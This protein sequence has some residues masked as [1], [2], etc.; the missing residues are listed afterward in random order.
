METNAAELAG[1]VEDLSGDELVYV[2]QHLIEGLDDS[3]A[4]PVVDVEAIEERFQADVALLTELSG[5]LGID[6]D[7]DPSTTPH[8]VLLAAVATSPEV[9]T[10]VVRAVAN[11]RSRST[12]PVDAGDI[13]L[14]I[15]ATAAALAIIRPKIVKKEKS[16]TFAKSK[17]F[18]FEV[19]GIKSVES[20]VRALLGYVRSRD[21]GS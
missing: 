5:G 20:L 16:D 19:Q 17:E 14:V 11:V 10:H 4:D 18:S 12:L 7:S 6:V 2:F 9:R 15:L 21:L 8:E 3:D 13:S 1:A